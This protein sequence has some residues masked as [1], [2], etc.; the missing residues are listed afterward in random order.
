[1]ASSQKSTLR[2]D[3]TML[4]TSSDEAADR[5][6]FV[7]NIT[8]GAYRDWP[9][10]AGVSPKLFPSPHLSSADRSSLFSA[11]SR[12]VLIFLFWLVTDGKCP[13]LMALQRSVAP[14]S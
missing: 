11:S 7:Q 6:E 3:T 14:Y 5:D 9:N 12:I 8:A 1:M 10:K 4:R 2:D 13:S